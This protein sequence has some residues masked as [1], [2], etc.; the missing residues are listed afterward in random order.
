MTLLVAPGGW[1]GLDRVADVEFDTELATGPGQGVAE[2]LAGRQSDH[3]DILDRLRD[4]V[5]HEH[6]ARVP[7]GREGLP[8]RR[9]G[10][11]RIAAVHC[12]RV[13]GAVLM[14]MVVFEA[15]ASRGTREDPGSRAVVADMERHADLL[16]ATATDVHD[17]PLPFP[18]VRVRAAADIRGDPA[19]KG[20]VAESG[21]VAPE[22]IL[23]G[24]RRST[25]R[26]RLAG[27]QGENSE[28]G[29]RA[30]YDS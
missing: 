5:A 22:E 26:H 17:E 24:G 27:D 8:V 6:V 14:A 30:L 18:R 15:Q 29:K 1:G 19:L 23:C 3:P 20:F 9:A 10:F 28:T 7:I 4:I 25:T 21:E 12:H 13:V 2:A 16:F 11:C